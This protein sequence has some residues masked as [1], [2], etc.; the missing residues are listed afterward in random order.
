VA[1]AVGAGG[2][3]GWRVSVAGLSAGRWLIGQRALTLS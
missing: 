2:V 1:L 3:D